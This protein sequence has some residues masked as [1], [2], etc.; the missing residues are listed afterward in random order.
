MI[1]PEMGER[2][3]D[4]VFILG[5]AGAVYLGFRAKNAI[6]EIAKKRTT[7]EKAS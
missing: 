1:T 5:L 2:L 4:V 7:E 3:I 6:K